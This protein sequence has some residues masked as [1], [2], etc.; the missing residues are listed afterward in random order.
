M[1]GS[2]D[3]AYPPEKQASRQVDGDAVEQIRN[4]KTPIRVEIC[5]E[6]FGA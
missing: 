4:G 5:T 2:N 1:L 6:H 3:V